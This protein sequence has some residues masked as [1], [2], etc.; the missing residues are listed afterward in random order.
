MDMLSDIFLWI[1]YSS[2]GASA[3]ALLV[4]LIKKLFK[5]RLSARIHYALWLIV[6]IRLLI[7]VFPTSSI[8]IFTLFAV[9]TDSAQEFLWFNLNQENGL[10]K[11]ANGSYQ[12]G[13]QQ[14]DSTFLVNNQGDTSI[15]TVHDEG[16]RTNQI[17]TS[18]ETSDSKHAL[19]IKV[20]SIVWLLGFIAM[21]YQLFRFACNMKQKNRFLTK[22]TEPNMLF[23]MDQCRKRF[24]ISKPIPIYTG[25][26]AKSP[27]ITD[28]LRPWVYCP[29][30][31]FIS[32]SDSQLTHIFSHELAHYKRRD[33]LWNTLG[34][35]ALTIHWMNPLVWICMKQMR[36]DMELACDAYVLEVIGEEETE[37]YGMTII[38]FLK[39]F[40]VKREHPYLLYFT[41]SNKVSLIERRIRM[42]SL[43][44]KGS[45]KLSAVA[46]I[47]GI[48]IS[49]VTLTNASGSAADIR[50]TDELDSVPTLFDLYS[51]KNK[52]TKEERIDGFTS[53]HRL[54]KAEQRA[55]FRFKVPEYIPEGYTFNSIDMYLNPKEMATA[56]KDTGTTQ[57]DINLV[58][59]FYGGGMLN[60][61]A[62]NGGLGIESAYQKI[63]EAYSQVERKNI[64]V[65]GL[66]ITKV[67]VA[68]PEEKYK[69]YYYMWLDNDIQ[70]QLRTFRI[71][72][73]NIV[74]MIISMKYPDLALYERYVNNDDFIIKIYDR[75]DVVQAQKMLGFIPKFPM[76]LS[77]QWTAKDAYVTKKVNF[78]FP[79]NEV[80]HETK[81]LHM[82]Y[83]SNDTK[84]T[85]EIKG[86]SFLQIK[87]SKIF[88]DMKKNGHAPFERIDGKKFVVKVTPLT[89]EGREVLKT[90]P[91]KID[92]EISSASEADITS[93]F[94]LENDI[95]YKVSFTENGDS[96]KK[97]I[98]NL[99]K[100]KLVEID[101]LQP[102]K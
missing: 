7:P 48:V 60:L 97:V 88:T 76:Q 20:V 52:V 78:S 71:S 65:D 45:Y 18:M 96:Q 23:I 47:C 70:Y 99:I 49:A 87:D 56:Q 29:R 46:V 9:G 36:A 67:T 5:H 72:Q 33:I 26:V 43:F 3:V 74:K 77:D 39:R 58:N 22:V 28:Q 53:S 80:E 34:M 85:D 10:T 51:F 61:S 12:Q 19:W 4:L 16:I 102:V 13:E 101:S 91:Y 42:I 84:K 57:K 63:K 32:M 55:S 54:E 64:N 37:A 69:D 83:G 38:D 79:E 75:E 8:S 94:W 21:L 66:K 27:Y 40:A 11:Q 24:G 90:D 44:K 92:E 100:E 50:S 82:S 31:V 89:I 17:A 95:C 1:F 25:D 62:T 68:P 6:V 15:T 73:E 81:V 30:E 2:V 59:I 98:A 41:K 93:Y 86:F 35:I 14:L